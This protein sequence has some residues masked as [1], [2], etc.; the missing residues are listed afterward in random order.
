MSRFIPPPPSP[1]PPSTRSAE[2]AASELFTEL[3]GLSDMKACCGAA[4]LH[5]FHGRRPEPGVKRL[6]GLQSGSA[7]SLPAAAVVVRG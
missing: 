1:P 5:R 6:L 7:A 2:A 4:A 3:Q